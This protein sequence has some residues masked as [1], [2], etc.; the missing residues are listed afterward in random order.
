MVLR[1][2]MEN[3]PFVSLQQRRLESDGVT[4]DDGHVSWCFMVNHGVR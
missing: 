1:V 2:L 3:V 4:G